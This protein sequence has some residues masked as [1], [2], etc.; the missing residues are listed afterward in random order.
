MR[1]VASCALFALAAAKSDGTCGY[2]CTTDTDCSGCGTAGKCSSPDGATAQFANISST[3]VSS[4]ANPPADPEAS[5][6]DSAWPSKWSANVDGYVYADFTTTA[7]TASGS[8]KYD[9]VLGKT[10]ADWKPYTSGKDATQIWIVDGTDSKY[11]V[12]SGALCLYFPI[13]DPG[14]T[15]TP[16]IGVERA[17]W[18][19]NCKDAG[20]AKYVG[21]EQVN[22]GGADEWVDHWSCHVDYAAAGQ[23]ITF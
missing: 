9:A 22:V 10:R 3:C 23:Q 7:A 4:P 19:K 12:K 5:A 16:T 6:D 21:R 14:Q 2:E 8:F 15:G 1:A 13:T 20:M 18:M 11:Y 17:D